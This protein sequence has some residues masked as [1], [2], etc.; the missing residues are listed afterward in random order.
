MLKKIQGKVDTLMRVAPYITPAK[1]ANAALNQAEIK[2]KRI[3]FRSL[4]HTLHVEPST[5][6]NTDCQLCPVGLKYHKDARE[7]FQ[8]FMALDDFKRIVDI[9]KKY[10]I[11]L[12]IG[13]WGEPTLNRDILP[14]VRYAHEQGMHTTVL[15]NGHYSRKKLALVKELCQ[16]L[17]A[18]LGHEVIQR[19][20]QP[21]I[22]FWV[23]FE[24]LE[25]AV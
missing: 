5:V 12:N 17:E 13:L 10:V 11:S 8:R 21:W 20:G 9:Y 18:R 15:T 19:D 25:E 22:S 16:G 2:A 24:D 7:E 23:D 4:P 1:L 6:C 3:R 14:M